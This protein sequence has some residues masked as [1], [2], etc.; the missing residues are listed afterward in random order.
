M[1]L[2]RLAVAKG[3]QVWGGAAGSQETWQPCRT[4]LCHSCSSVLVLIQQDQGAEPGHNF[5]PS[6]GGGRLHYQNNKKKGYR[7]ARISFQL[8]NSPPAKRS[9]GLVPEL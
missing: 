5:V 7:A 3:L 1:A 2:P 4:V 6:P 8:P 9:S